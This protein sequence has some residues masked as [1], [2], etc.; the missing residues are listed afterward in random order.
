MMFIVLVGNNAVVTI[1]HYLCI[2]ILSPG[3]WTFEDFQECFSLLCS[4]GN[5]LR[6]TE[7]SSPTSLREELPKTGDVNGLASFHLRSQSLN[8]LNP[9]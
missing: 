6:F 9:R 2:E 3:T 4:S 1:L 8:M 7:G 5:D